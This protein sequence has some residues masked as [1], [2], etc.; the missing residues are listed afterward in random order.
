MGFVLQTG[1]ARICNVRAI[2]RFRAPLVLYPFDEEAFRIRRACVRRPTGGC[3]RYRHR[4]LFRDPTIGPRRLQSNRE[5]RQVHSQPLA[6]RLRR[7]CC[8]RAR[9]IA[10][11]GTAP[12][13]RPTPGRQG[14]GRPLGRRLV[15]RLFVARL[16]DI[17]PPLHHLHLGQGAQRPLSRFLVVSDAMPRSPF[18][19]DGRLLW[20]WLWLPPLRI[21]AG[22]SFTAFV[23]MICFH[24]VTAR[25]LPL[26]QV[27]AR[28]EQPNGSA[29][30]GAETAP[31]V[32]LLSAPTKPSER[33]AR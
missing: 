21:P 17:A 8:Q 25:D 11:A 27:H 5:R 19:R 23:K 20:L 4:D 24:G 26:Q 30:K 9:V 12:W 15:V 28:V 16:Q 14:G 22:G 18:A 33:R 32:H 6:G 2:G 29:C 13:A 7:R 3:S 1:L 10:K 31:V